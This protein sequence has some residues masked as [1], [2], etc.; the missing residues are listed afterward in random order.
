MA[1][2]T[3]VTF[4]ANWV[5]IQG[6]TGPKSIDVLGQGPP[7]PPLVWEFKDSLG[8]HHVGVSMIGGL[9]SILRIYFDPNTDPQKTPI[10]RIGPN[11]IGYIQ[12]IGLQFRGDNID[13]AIL[14]AL[15]A[16]GYYTAPGEKYLLDMMSPLD[17]Q[18]RFSVQNPV[19]KKLKV[20][21]Q[22][23]PLYALNGLMGSVTDINMVYWHP[24]PN[25]SVRLG[26]P[27]VL[28]DS[29]K[30]PIP[31]AERALVPSVRSLISLLLITEDDLKVFCTDGDEFYGGAVTTI[32]AAQGAVAAY[33]TVFSQKAAAIGV[34]P[35]GSM[36]L[37]PLDNG[38]RI[39]M[40][41]TTPAATAMKLWVVGEEDYDGIEQ[42]ASLDLLDSLEVLHELKGAAPPTAPQGRGQGGLRRPSWLVWLTPAKPLLSLVIQST[43]VEIMRDTTHGMGIRA[44]SR[45]ETTF[46]WIFDSVSERFMLGPPKAA[47]VAAGP[48]PHALGKAFVKAATQVPPAGGLDTNPF[49]VGGANVF[50]NEPARIPN[51]KAT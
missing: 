11:K 18:L 49:V 40:R 34:S 17:A 6:V 42:R 13:P 24:A 45:V 15:K 10:N 30:P 33:N 9:T 8:T 12:T 25:G 51:T 3:Q 14:P 21:T 27:A 29:S 4:S 46:D 7:L 36:L 23:H 48:D 2:L 50:T 16:K 31:S 43:L 35:I 44:C 39:L 22:A 32:G 37:I 47:L 28:P 1:L 20:F 5:G 41:F 19:D 38:D 26:D